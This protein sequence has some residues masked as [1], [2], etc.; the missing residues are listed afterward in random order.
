MQD[1]VT[2]AAVAMDGRRRPCPAARPGLACGVQ[3]MGDGAGRFP[4]RVTREDRA[5]HVD[6]MG[7]GLQFALADDVIP[8]A[9]AAARE[10]GLDPCRQAST[11]LHGQVVQEEFVHRALEADVNPVDR[12]FGEGLQRDAGVGEAFEDAGDVLLVARKSIKSLRHDVADFAALHC[13]EEGAQSWSI[14]DRAAGN[15]LITE[16]ED[17]RDALSSAGLA[18]QCDL[19]CG[20]SGV[21]EVGG[22]AA[23]D[24][25]FLGAK[26]QGISRLKFSAKKRLTPPV[27]S[28][29]MGG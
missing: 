8:I 13:S 17:V 16:H 19:V 27:V 26:D 4:I 10:A 1:A 6:L 23:V 12:A 21:L 2:G 3:A 7:V 29:Y 25:A 15:G 11:R 18:Q 20:R 28:S 9:A 24:G 22:M 14:G 5:D